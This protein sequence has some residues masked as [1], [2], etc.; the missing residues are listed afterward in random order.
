MAQDCLF[1]C[2]APSSFLSL[3]LSVQV[4]GKYSKTIDIEKGYFIELFRLDKTFKI[5]DPFQPCPEVP[6]LHVF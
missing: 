1:T 2:Q 4:I 3:L 6:C 5:D